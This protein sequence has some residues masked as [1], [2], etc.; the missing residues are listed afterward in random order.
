MNHGCNFDRPLLACLVA[1]DVPPLSACWE[2][3]VATL[4]AVATLEAQHP[5]V[6]GRLREPA[7][8]CKSCS[9]PVRPTVPVVAGGECKRCLAFGG[10]GSCGGLSTLKYV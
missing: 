9:N 6:S 3:V 4:K 2:C 7:A 5:H 10:G 1:S 8:V